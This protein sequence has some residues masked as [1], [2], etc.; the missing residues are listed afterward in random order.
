MCI[1][2]KIV[3][4]DIP[5]DRVFENSKYLAFLDINPVNKGHTLV[6]PKEHSETMLDMTSE[7]FSE[8]MDITHKVAKGV[9]KIVDPDG[10]NLIINNKAA[11]GQEVPHV[12]VH[13]IPRHNDDPFKQKFPNTKYDSDDE[14]ESIKESIRDLLKSV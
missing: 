2:C 9:I 11:S 3:K 6:I 13:I 7:D 1:F 5:A 10:Y 4:G 12:H 14:K 8:L